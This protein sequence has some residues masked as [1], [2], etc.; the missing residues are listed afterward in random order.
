MWDTNE[1][2]LDREPSAVITKY[3]IKV[4]IKAVEPMPNRAGHDLAP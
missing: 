1:G 4:L 3:S 2:L